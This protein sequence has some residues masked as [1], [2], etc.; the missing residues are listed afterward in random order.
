MSYI[1]DALRRADAERRRTQPPLQQVTQA[2]GWPADEPR[3]APARRWLLPLL[4]VLA[5]LAAAGLGLLLWRGGPSAQTATPLAA[6]PPTA[7]APPAV[8]AAPAP[9]SAPM[10]VITEPRAQTA[11]PP[12]PR[13]AAPP[14]RPAPPRARAA[15][16]SPPATP[17]TPAPAAPAPEQAVLPSALPD[18]QR[19]L[20][21][22]LG[23][24][25]AVHS[26]DRAQ[27][28][29]LQGGQ[30]VR[31]GQAVAPGVTLERIEPHAL[32]LRVGERLVRW[33][34]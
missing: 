27:S 10:A 13:P 18:A 11:V 17:A 23:F 20:L 5:L 33:P 14:R 28:F 3:P 22:G 6:A 7:A 2:A 8:V 21:D 4:L 19:R 12:R 32:L 16:S 15:A 25:G 34:L 1:L 9:A 31:E 24:G 29:V 26:Q 30:L